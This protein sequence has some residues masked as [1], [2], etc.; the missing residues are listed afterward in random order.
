MAKTQAISGIQKCKG[1]S[2]VMGA[3]I[4]HIVCGTLYVWSNINT[5]YISYL[6]HHDSPNIQITDGYFLMP[7]A[8]FVNT[9]SSWI[10]P[11]LDSCIHIKA[12]VFVSIL[13]ISAANFLIY[14][15]TCE[16]QIHYS[17]IFIS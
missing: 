3:L 11:I 9:F 8:A 14:Y 13:L 1:I 5:Y 17:L 15:S 2:S 12:C 16:F 7:L 10:G 4:L 6:K